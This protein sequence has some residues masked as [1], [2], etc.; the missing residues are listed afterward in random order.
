MIP[1]AVK[2]RADSLSLT[3]SLLSC[4]FLHPSNCALSYP[5]PHKMASTP[6]AVSI[7]LTAVLLLHL[8]PHVTASVNRVCTTNPSVCTGGTVCVGPSN[9]RLCRKPM[10]RG[11]RCNTDPYWVCRAGLTCV[12]NQCRIPLNA[13]CLFGGR[14]SQ[15]CIAGTHCVGTATRKL[16]R[17][18]MIRGQRCNTDPFWVCR[19]GLTCVSNQC[20]IP[21]N[22]NCLFGGQGSRFCVAGTQCVGT[23]TRKICKRAMLRG[24]RCNTDPF[25]VCRIGLTCVRNQCRI[26]QDANC[27]FGGRASQFCIAGTS[28]VGLTNR[29][30]C[31]KWMAPGGR[32]NTDPFWKCQPGYPCVSNICRIRENASCL[33]QRPELCAPGTQCV[34][35]ATRKICKKWMPIGGRCNTDPFW[36]CQPGV[37]CVSN[38]CRIPVDG[39]CTASNAQLCAPGTSCI[40]GKC[41]RGLANG[42]ACTANGPPCGS[43]LV[44]EA[45]RCRGQENANCLPANSLC[46]NGLVCAGNKDRKLC[47]K[48]MPLGG[49]CGTDPFW[50][51]APGITCEDRVCRLPSGG[52][53][54]RNT[55]ACIKKALCVG[56]NTQKF[57]SIPMGLNE[58]CAVDP[59]WIC[60]AGL[61]CVSNKCIRPL[62]LG[63]RCE[64][65]ERND[66][67]NSAQ[68]LICAGI[69]GR[70]I[71]VRAIREFGRCG[72]P[73]NVCARPMSCNGGVC[74]ASH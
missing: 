6:F 3:R 31:K 4:T 20:R 1:K 74:Q 61:R 13:N 50:V 21:E 65:G 11:Q 9:R 60:V 58:P 16:C 67:C 47:R 55:G 29:K 23:A 30:V 40:S 64:T 8:S 5:L 62:G 15:F 32:C 52:D 39:T 10:I 24:Q 56:T 12:N 48:P 44:C 28:C 59:F 25:W 72:G 34:G 45:S 66:A 2:Y 71:C 19:N 53:C 14:P 69:A 18:P 73:M 38:I 37:P 41:V 22:V 7:L 63:A 36:R 35:T 68:G 57:C 43:R 46:A 42:A 26:P 54:T 33:N 51:C 49:R 27:L 17:K 70:T